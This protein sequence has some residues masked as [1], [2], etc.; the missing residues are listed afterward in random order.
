MAYFNALFRSCL[1]GLD[2]TRDISGYPVPG[3]GYNVKPGECHVLFL[4]VS[5]RRQRK[6]V[7]ASFVT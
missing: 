2:G 7:L 3:L 6:G 4:D 5:S 1:Y